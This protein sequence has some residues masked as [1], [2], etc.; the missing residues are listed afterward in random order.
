MLGSQR[1]LLSKISLRANED[2]LDR[3]DALPLRPIVKSVVFE[4]VTTVRFQV[5][6]GIIRTL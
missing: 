4:P 3:Y 2:A 1:K 5:I 6:H